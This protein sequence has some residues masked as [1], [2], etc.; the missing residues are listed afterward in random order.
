ME[1]AD[2]EP[3]C[4]VLI[5]LPHDEAP[6]NVF[7]PTGFEAAERGTGDDQDGRERIHDTSP[8]PAQKATHL[9]RNG[10]SEFAC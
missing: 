4:Q 6:K 9:M 10:I 5:G 8:D 1:L 7:A 2:L 3:R